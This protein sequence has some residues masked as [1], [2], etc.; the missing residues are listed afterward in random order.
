MSARLR[1]GLA[2]LTVLV[3]VLSFVVVDAHARRERAATGDALSIALVEAPG[4]ADLSLSSGSRWL[5]HPSVAEPAAACVGPTCLDVD[6][7]GLALPP[8][9]ETF[10]GGTTIVRVPE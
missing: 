3:L 9:R 1:N 4:S 2:T 5:R 6:P 7:A 8:P 10:V